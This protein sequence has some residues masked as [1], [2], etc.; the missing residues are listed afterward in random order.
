R[1]SFAI[2]PVICALCAA[3]VACGPSVSGDDDDDDGSGDAGNGDG[4]NACNPSFPV[5][6]GDDIHTC[7]ADGTVGPLVET[8]PGG[9]CIN[10][11]CNDACAAA[12]AN[13]SYIGCE[14]WPVDLDNAVEVQGTEFLPGFGCP[15]PSGGTAPAVNM[16]VCAQG[17]NIYGLCDYGNS[18]AGAPTS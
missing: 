12:V 18:C 4:N 2:V 14:Y 17:N 3:L 10:G 1:A 8:C 7:N 6:V 5:C 9:T 15:Q 16:M 11:G 13:R